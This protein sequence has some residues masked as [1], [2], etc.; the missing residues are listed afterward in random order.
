[1]TNRAVIIFLYAIALYRLAPGRTFGN[2]TVVDIAM[3]VIIGSTLSRALTGNA[4]LLPVFAATFVLLMVHLLLATVALRSERVSW[5]IKGRPLQLI[6][7]GEIDWAAM[8]RAK[9]G[10][11][12]LQE[13]LRL[14]GVARPEQV[15]EG[16]L[17][18]NGRV[19]ILRNEGS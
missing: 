17:E 6:R 18:R 4:P 13:Q 5:L 3:T 16:W 11:R 14:Q 9:F 7:D 10:E 15:A 19:S 8:K 2:H 1:M 12:D